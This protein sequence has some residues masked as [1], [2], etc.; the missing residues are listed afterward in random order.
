MS[1]SVFEA[2]REAPD[3]AALLEG[4]KPLSFAELAAATRPALAELGAAGLVGGDP[5]DLPVAFDATPDRAA[6]LR[7]H[8]LMA[9]G[10]PALPLHPGLSHEER[11]ALLA[12]SP[13]RGD[14]GPS[15]AVAPSPADAPEP[16]VAPDD[17]RSLAV[18][19]T[20]GS[21]GGPRGV[22]LSRRAFAASARAS[23]ANLGWR[24]DDRWLLSL[25]VAH[26]GGLSVVTRCL[27][28]RRAVV[29]GPPPGLAPSAIEALIEAVERDRVTLLSLVPAQL[30]ALLERQPAWRPPAAVR[31][32]LLGGGPAAPELRRR[33][34]ERGWPI[35]AT[36][37]LTEACSQVATQSPDDAE[38]DDESCG[39]ALP[40][41]ELRIRDA[42]L[43]VRGPVL[44]SGYH[45]PAES[46]ATS[47]GW[48]PTRDRAEI[49]ATGRLRVLGR[50]DGAILSGGE[51]VQ[52]EEV[53]QALET[54]TGVARACVF[55]LPD[56]L[57]GE[58]LGAAVAPRPGCVLDAASLAREWSSRL[59]P[60]RRP[61]YLAILAALPSTPSGKLDRRRTREAAE[62]TLRPVPR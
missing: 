10:I 52:P 31:A 2:A 14:L 48:H 16:P 22:V 57:R 30:Q 3:V 58:V 6:L 5:D 15:P 13:H 1:L 40:G 21:T 50:S 24:P 17:E 62:A 60:F 33:A 44:L 37:G 32:A 19:Q 42:G 59:A 41:I 56:P 11:T 43:E 39:R 8:A 47:D 49:D 46:P 54:C 53:E 4:G 51:T 38:P 36:Y 34:R 9:L 29:L 25:P 45:P 55:G 7:L 20:S 26:V 18:I 35:L 23:A 28:A 12:R 27:L 61:R